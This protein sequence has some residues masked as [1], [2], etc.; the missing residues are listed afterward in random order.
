MP[1]KSPRNVSSIGAIDVIQAVESALNAQFAERTEIIHGLFVALVAKQNLVLLGPPGAAKTALA[2]AFAE[3]IGMK[4]W[5]T[6]LTRFSTPEELFGPLSLKALEDD[7]YRRNPAGMLPESQVALVDEIFKANSAILNAMLSVLNERIWHNDGQRIALPLQMLIGA[8]N[9]LPEGDELDAL[10]DRF[11]LR[12]V[13]EY[14]EDPDTWEAW[15]VEGVASPAKEIDPPILATTLESQAITALQAAAN[16]V[17]AREIVPT[18]RQLKADLESDYGITV[19]DRRWSVVVKLLKAEAAL[20]G[21]TTV[22]RADLPII[23][24]ALWESPDQKNDAEK[25]VLGFADPRALKILELR[26]EAQDL[27][28][29]VRVAAPEDLAS[30]VS[31]AS[32][33]MKVLQTQAAQLGDPTLQTSIHTAHTTIMRMG[34]KQPKRGR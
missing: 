20:R 11:A 5:A 19:S 8:S 16:Q 34:M 30:A 12:Y 23:T 7:R 28:E 15:L 25:V 9:E 3:A 26:T 29:S 10:W 13:I 2:Q 33:Q 4:Y 24:A 32:R 6:L 21:R 17:D 27:V 31:N 22:T 14:I 18:L 1:K